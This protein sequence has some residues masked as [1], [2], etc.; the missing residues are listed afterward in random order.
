MRF[1]PKMLAA[2]AFAATFAAIPAAYAA[3]ESD[4]LKFADF[5]A[6]CDTDKDGMLSKAEIVKTIEK[7]FDKHDR[8]KA[9]KLD[10]KQ[11]EALLRELMR[12]GGGG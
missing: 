9:G 5:M 3:A 12:G 8:K 7:V 10:T 6:M 2:A 4:D 1:N 11:T